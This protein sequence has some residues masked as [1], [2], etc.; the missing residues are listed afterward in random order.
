MANQVKFSDLFEG[1]DE[2]IAGLERQISGVQTTLTNMLGEVK[3]KAEEMY[4]A[5]QGVSSATKT[6]RDAT[7]AYAS[8]VER[9][10]K[11]FETLTNAIGEMT[12]QQDGMRKSAKSGSHDIQDLSKSYQTLGALV[13]ETGL[14]LDDLLVSEKALT[15][16]T[17]NGTIANNALRGSYEQLYAQYNLIKIV[18]NNMGAEMRNNTKIGG[19][20]ET[21][22]L[23]I[24]NTLKM[25]Q[26]ATGKHTLSVGDYTKAFNGLNISTQQVLRE[27]PTLANSL[28]QFFIAIS[29]NVPIFVDNFKAVQNVTGSFMKAMGA[30]LKSLFSWQTVLLGLLT[31]LPGI[32]KRISE[33]KKAQEEDNEVSRASIKI[34]QDLK[35]IYQDIDKSINGNV[36]QL[37]TLYRV[38]QDTNRSMGER[39]K[40]ARELKT[41]YEDAFKNYTAEE[42]ALGEAKRAY[43][44]LT[45]TLVEQAKARAYL[46]KI[47]A[48]EEQVIDQTALRDQAKANLD[49]AKA[50]TARA[51]AQLEAYDTWVKTNKVVGAGGAEYAT[52]SDRIAKAEEAEAKANAEFIKADEPLQKIDNAI[53]KLRDELPAYGVQ[54]S[55]VGSATKDTTDKMKDY[56]WDYRESVNRITEDFL[57]KE[58]DALNIDIDRKKQGYETALTDLK[59]AGTL[60]AEQEE[61]L[62]NILANLETERQRR[63][64]D[65]IIEWLEKTQRDVEVL[66]EDIG[67]DDSI[68]GRYE[69][70][71]AEQSKKILASRVK[72]NDAIESNSYREAKNEGKIFKDLTIEKLKLEA[73]FQR[74]LL[75]MRLD[76]G[77]ITQDQYDI[78]LAG[79]EEK[80]AKSIAGLNKRGRKQKFSIWNLLFGETK[81]D[82]KGNVFK[83]LDEEAKAFVDA[84]TSSMQ[85]AFDYMDEWMDKRIEMAEIAVEAAQKES[86]AAKTALDYEMQARANGYANNVE[87]ARKEYEEKLKLEQDA[88]AEKERLQK[89]QEAIDT[90]TQFSSLVTATAELWAA[91]AGIPFV[92]AALAAVAT[93][94]MWASFAAAKITAAQMTSTKYGEGMA[95]YLDYGGSHA[96]G[97]DI[98]FGRD[99]RGRQRRVERGEVIGVINKRNVDKYGVKT[100]TDVIN[101]LNKGTFESKY[102]LADVVAPEMNADLY[103]LAFA[104]LDREGVSLGGVESRLQTLIE[105]GETRVVPTADGRIEYRG[106]SKRIIHNS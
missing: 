80:L 98:D 52:F 91:H 8:E 87:L 13:A 94:A 36:S 84:F 77:E 20:W 81:E 60:T 7:S 40:V 25:M 54:L 27:L 1:F 12:R 29:N 58:L 14:Y 6:D 42:I 19:V 82:G 17:K 53:A 50:E 11:D 68:S 88:I 75:K 39:V 74:E 4:G 63:R 35:K 59:N 41:E 46:N 93:A 55:K 15:Q 65:I 102:T 22:A 69:R 32:A 100:V 21:Q 79:I 5:L 96:S 31:I 2:G 16:A 24:M 97:N 43:E 73:D 47:T 49:L 89:I 99:K 9:L 48:L 101:S 44:E 78:E 95:E 34:L 3:K 86:E 10:H 51:K 103:H 70:L 62:T 61:Y 72:L 83:E 76:T 106:N 26:E 18:L 64:H 38:S 37:R 85:M 67:E 66:T 30:V 105:Q 45:R 104:G 57:N 28:Q 92:G 33:K 56:Y 90:A 71:L 23:S